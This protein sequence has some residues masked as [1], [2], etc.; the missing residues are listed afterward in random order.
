MVADFIGFGDARPNYAALIEI[1]LR[2]REHATAKRAAAGAA[3]RRARPTIERRAMLEAGVDAKEK[4]LAEARHTLAVAR[5]HGREEARPAAQGRRITRTRWSP[6]TPIRPTTRRCRRSP[7]PTARTTCARCIWRRAGRRRPRM[8]PSCAGWRRSMRRSARR[9]R[10][11]AGLRAAMVELSRRRAEVEQVRDRF[12][13]TGYDHP[14]TTFDNE[15]AIADALKQHPGGRGAQRRAVGPAAPGLQVAT[16][17]RQPGLRR[18]RASRFP[19]PLP[20]GTSGRGGSRGDDWREPSSR[21]SWSPGRGSRSDDD[22]F[23][24]G[25]SF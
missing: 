6:A 11:I 22:D 18:R 9:T 8:R 13:R 14:Q 24:T 16:D 5:R 25:G 23:T 20:D 15:G 1:P 3:A 17:A 21:G 19:F 2:L 10:E 7:Q 12:R 4:A